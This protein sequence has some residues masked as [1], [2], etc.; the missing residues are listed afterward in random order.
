[1]KY[2]YKQSSFVNNIESFCQKIQRKLWINKQPP[3]KW[4]VSRAIHNGNKLRQTNW[5]SFHA[6]KAK[7]FWKFAKMPT[8]LSFISYSKGAD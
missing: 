1:M 7:T 5:V 8:F 2:D 6:K 3:L 4:R